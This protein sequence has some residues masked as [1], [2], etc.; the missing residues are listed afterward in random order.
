MD[1]PLYKLENYYYYLECYHYFSEAHKLIHHAASNGVPEAHRALNE[2]CTRGGCEW[3]L[4]FTNNV[5]ISLVHYRTTYYVQYFND[6]TQTKLTFIRLVSH[7]LCLSG[8][9]VTDIKDV[10]HRYPQGARKQWCR[11]ISLFIWL[12]HTY[13]RP[14]RPSRSL[15]TW[16]HF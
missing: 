5:R 9:E 1:R 2:I 12:G 10:L 8:D 16:Y 15:K 13:W 4:Q 7:D 3:T 11:Y 14:L 6:T